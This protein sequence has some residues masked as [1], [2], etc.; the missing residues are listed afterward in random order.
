MGQSQS[1]F[2]RGKDTD[3][4][5]DEILEQPLYTSQCTV[6]CYE[7][8]EMLVPDGRYKRL[9]AFLGIHDWEFESDTKKESSHRLMSQIFYFIK[10]N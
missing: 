7:L 5:P 4:I 1:S 8:G 6:V 3:N 10:T 2:G 9:A